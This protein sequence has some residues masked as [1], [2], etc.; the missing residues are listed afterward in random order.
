MEN[1]NSPFTYQHAPTEEEDDELDEQMDAMVQF[2][3]YH[4]QPN[5]GQ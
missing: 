5:F 1:F 4:N 2:F 3:N